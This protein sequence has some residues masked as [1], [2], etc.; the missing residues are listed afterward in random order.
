MIQKNQNNN[1]GWRSR[2]DRGAC[3]TVEMR[4]RISALLVCFLARNWEVE[5][6]WI[7]EVK[8]L[9]WEVRSGEKETPTVSKQIE[10]K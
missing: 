4:R 8:K 10:G 1:V 6:L 5:L 2:R 9:D 7:L 3:G